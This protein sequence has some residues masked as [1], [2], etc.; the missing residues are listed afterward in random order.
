MV[1]DT[2]TNPVRVSNMVRLQRLAVGIG[3][4][5]IGFVDVVV[6][7]ALFGPQEE[8][9]VKGNDESRTPQ[10]PPLVFLFSLRFV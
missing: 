1:P 8:E 9:K 7:I 6:A 3:V 5:G 4:I 2:T 10:T